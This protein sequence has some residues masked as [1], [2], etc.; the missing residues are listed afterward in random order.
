MQAVSPA[1]LRG[2]RVI[3]MGQLIAGP[4]A[5]KTLGDFGAEVIKIEPPGRGDPL[6]GWRLLKAGTSVWWQVQSRHPRCI[7][8]E[9]MGLDTGIDRQD[10]IAADTAQPDTG[11]VQV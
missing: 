11:D 9:P 3:E 10:R 5:G 8:F 2:V 1:A 6:R 7:A 4:F